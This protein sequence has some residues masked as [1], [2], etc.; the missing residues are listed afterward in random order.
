MRGPAARTN[1]CLGKELNAATAGWENS[2]QQA[3]SVEGFTAGITD[4]SFEFVFE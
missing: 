4:G 2:T 1:W 3:P